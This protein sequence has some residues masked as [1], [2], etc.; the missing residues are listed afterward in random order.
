MY[1]VTLCSR[2]CVCVC[3][4]EQGV[5]CVIVGLLGAELVIPAHLSFCFVFL[6]KGKKLENLQK[7][8][9]QVKPEGM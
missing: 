1:H 7:A 9:K 2:E 6:Q 5:I 3:Y 8:Q 4:S